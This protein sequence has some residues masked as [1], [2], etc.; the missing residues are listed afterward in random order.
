MNEE[1]KKAYLQLIQQLLNCE[2][3]E[4]NQILSDNRELV[5]SELLWVIAEVAEKFADNGKSNEANFLINLLLQLGAY[6]GSSQQPQTVRQETA[7]T[8]FDLGVRWFQTS[9]FTLALQVWQYTL[10]IYQEIKDRKGE[11]ACLGNLGN[12]YY[13]LGQYERAIEYTQKSFTIYQEIKHRQGEA[14]SLGNLGNAY[15]SLGQYERAI[16]FH[17]ESL[18]IDREIKDRK[19]EAASLGNLGNSY[20]FLGQYERAIEYHQQSLTISREIKDRKGEAI[21]F[22][23]L[24]NSYGSLGQYERAIEF[25]QQSL[26][27]A[28]KIK[29]RNGEAISLNN[30]GN[31]YR[32]LGQYEQ[33]IEYHQ[34]S[35]T[36]ARDIQ[37]RNGE[38]N[39][40]NNL[41]VAYNFLGQYERAIEYHQQSLSISRKLKDR[42][43][44]AISLGNL[45]NAYDS[46]GQ[47]EP[48]IDYIQQSLTIVREIKDRTQ[49]AT[50]LNNLGNVHR[51][52]GRTEAAIQAF[53]DSLK[54]AAPKTMP[55]NCIYAGRNLGNIAFTQGN[56]ELAITGYEPAIQAIELTR[57]S[58]LTDDR[59]KQ[60]L[61]DNLDAYT[62]IV[63][64]YIN[65]EQY[66]KALEYADRSRS[67]F[68]ADLFHNK[69]LYSRGDIPP[70]VQEYLDL[71]QQ[72]DRLRFNSPSDDMMG[73][74]SSSPAS[75]EAKL[76]TIKQLAAKKQQV[77]ES[78]RRENNELAAQLQPT[79]LSFQQ[80]QKLIGDRKTALL[81]FY[82]T[83]NDT[84]I[85]I[86]RHQDT[87][88]PLDPSII[89]PARG[90][91]IAP[92]P[93]RRGLG[94]G[95]E[96]LGERS[97]TCFTCKGQGFKTLQN[98]IKET[99]LIPYINIK[100]AKLF[101]AAQLLNRQL[102]EIKLIQITDTAVLVT[103]T[104]G[105]V[106]TIRDRQEF[107]KQTRQKRTQLREQWKNQ[108]QPTLAE[109]SQRLQLRQLIENH[110]QD[111]EELIIV[112][113]LHLH[114][115]P[116]AA[117][118]LSELDPEKRTP[119]TPVSAGKHRGYRDFD[120]D[121]DEEPKTPTQP[122][123]SKIEYLCDRFQIRVVPSCQ[124]LDFCHQRKPV[125]TNI[126]GI[127]ENATGDLDCTR[128][129]CQKVAELYS[130]PQHRHL[131]KEEATVANYLKLAREVNLLHS[132]HHASSNLSNA[133]ESGLRLSDGTLD[134]AHLFIQ[135]FPQLSEVFLSCCE[136]NFS[137]SEM[138]DDVLTLAG[139][140]LTAGARSVVSTLWRVQDNSTAEFCQLYYQFRNR[141]EIRPEA[142]RKAQFELRKTEY[143]N[144]PYYWAAFVSQ[145]LR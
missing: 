4:K 88:S 13:S 76:E 110:L 144:H 10:T 70:Q 61:E 50:L 139:G 49:E 94:R 69:D 108:M 86:L 145:G 62:K 85:F 93:R 111:I 130:V 126:V 109:L 36:I 142:L 46:L 45:G 92:S 132:S 113:H 12:A 112:P 117:L 75:T 134:L 52:L 100:Q 77:W 128:E 78:I 25:H 124:I 129:E 11:S 87:N 119:S 80:M 82:T 37:D 137:L 26:T 60:V 103:L 23:N 106:E 68:L 102:D 55:N 140:F 133:L 1:R 44:E 38:A 9:Q 74:R 34:Q 47:Y 27:I 6:L 31:S 18:T 16:E 28:R 81:N 131:K 138:T 98:W 120:F 64:C 96:G 95:G 99:W 115:I 79:P 15:N 7:D 22:N 30:L 40:L 29:D 91:T 121:M 123:L 125:K 101:V 83:D 118:P 20:Q 97:I 107:L 105:S 89:S 8:L 33:A 24:G 58:S 57:N 43:G 53:R 35:L 59:R 65:L 141:G 73:D 127:V 90:D 14:N 56:W 135:R 19:G 21:S 48:A 3:G 5:E 136:T 84:F 51:E 63:Q 17:E 114:Q 2:S 39:S 72:I 67:R 54:I 66:D 104:D 143:F 71:Q 41:G 122:H 42:T 32:S 116:F